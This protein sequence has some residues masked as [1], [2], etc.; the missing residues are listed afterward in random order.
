MKAILI[1]AYNKKIKEVTL[2]VSKDML[3]Q[4]HEHIKCDTMTVAHYI[5][6]HDAILVDD[7]G[8]LKSP[9]HFFHYTDGHQ[10]F[11][12]N[13]LILGIDKQGETEECN[14]SLKE[15]KENVSF[16]SFQEQT[17]DI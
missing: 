15:V 1:D 11:A 12:G 4:Y 10:P 16:Y 13:G 3:D 5:N 2:D 17:S 9:R 7:E 8:L 6:N 14:I